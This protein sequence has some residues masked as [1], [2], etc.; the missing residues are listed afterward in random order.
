MGA[1]EGGRIVVGSYPPKSGFSFGTLIVSAVLGGVLGYFS[2]QLGR[3]DNSQEL[4]DV[5]DRLNNSISQIRASYDSLSSEFEDFVSGQVVDT[6]SSSYALSG[7]VENL[8]QNVGKFNYELNNLES[9]F[10]NHVSDAQSFKDSA[11]AR[12]EAVLSRIESNSQ[13]ISGLENRVDERL[14]NLK[15][16]VDVATG[17]PHQ[18]KTSLYESIISVLNNWTS[19][20]NENTVK[21]KG[22]ASF[23]NTS[24]WALSDFSDG[25]YGKLDNLLSYNPQIRDEI[26]SLTN[27]VLRGD[28]DVATINDEVKRLAYPLFEEHLKSEYR[29]KYKETHYESANKEWLESLAGN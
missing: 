2:G 14:D 22:F 20:H 18:I 24:G 13:D 1:G 4:S 19:I 23:L 26:D 25:D 7:D 16:Y 27:R 12:H 10:G 5:E 9:S 3:E 11:S 17:R 28:Q 6:G 21:R 29:F 8:K 15:N